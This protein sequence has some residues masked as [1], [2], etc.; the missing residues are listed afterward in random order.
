MERP[1]LPIVHYGLTDDAAAGKGY[2]KRITSAV[3]P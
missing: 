1:V 2:T 3:R